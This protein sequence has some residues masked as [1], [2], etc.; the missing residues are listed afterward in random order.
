MTP[1]AE[2]K[3]PSVALKPILD[4]RRRYLNREL[5]WLAFNWRVLAEASNTATPC[6]ND[7]ASSRYRRAISMNFSWC[8]SPVS[9]ARWPTA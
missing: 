4:P 1:L 8:A 5:S 9:R 2:E 6:S 7:C 3:S